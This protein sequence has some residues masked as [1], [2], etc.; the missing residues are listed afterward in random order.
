MVRL[1]PDMLRLFG[2]ATVFTHTEPKAMEPVALITGVVGAT[3]L[4]LTATVS[5]VLTP[6]PLIL[7]LPD[8]G[9]ADC[10][11]KCTN[12][13]VAFNVPLVNGILMDENQV[14]LS[15]DTWKFVLGAVM[16]I[17]PGAP[18]RFVPDTLND[19]DAE[20][21]PTVTLPKSLMVPVMVK[22][23][24]GGGV[25]QIKIGVAELRGAGAANEK[26][27]RLLLVSVQPPLFLKAAS[28]TLKTVVGAV[29]EQFAVP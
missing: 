14:M 6:P 10:G 20:L 27:D 26:S 12:T 4:P 3:P 17:L 25:P 9:P 19:C 23:G 18:V 8:C 5:A 21:L 24:A 2:P 16:L 29:S 13:C 11:V 15:R 1:E 28:L 22:T 7:I